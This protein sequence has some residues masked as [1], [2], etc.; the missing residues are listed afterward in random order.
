MDDHG[1]FDSVSWQREDAQQAEASMPF[2]QPS[3]L[4]TRP[5]S[6]RRSDSHSSEPQAGEQADEVDLAG[7]GRDGVLEVTVDTP[8]KEND[9][10][11]DAYVSYLVRTHVSSVLAVSMRLS[12]SRARPTSNPSRSQSSRFVDVLQILS[13]SD[14]LYIE[15]I[16][17]ALFLPYLKRTIW[18]MSEVTASV[19]SSPSVEHGLC[20]GLSSA[21]HYT[22][23]YGEQQSSFYSSRQPTGTH[24]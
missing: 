5:V 13:S 3:N 20:I 11:K 17:P 22:R 1:D 4:P 8:L 10:T 16:R 6:G 21:A 2:S 9:G 18:R 19:P 14:R 12:N 15:I 23:C 24:R 7:I